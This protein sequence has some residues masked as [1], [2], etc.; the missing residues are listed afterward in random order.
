LARFSRLWLVY[1]HED[2]LAKP[3]HFL[4]FFTHILITYTSWSDFF[5]LSSLFNHLIAFKSFNMRASTTSMILAFCAMLAVQS[6]PLSAENALVARGDFEYD[7]AYV[8]STFDN[9]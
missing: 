4:F 3:C 7:A 6:A 8:P 9:T 5:F 2:Y 1:N